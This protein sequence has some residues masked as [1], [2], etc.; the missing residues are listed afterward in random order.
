MM[1]IGCDFH[2]SW[3][4]VSWLDTETGE[5][6]EQKLVQASGD[7]ERFYRRVAPPALIGMEATGNCH[8]LVDL[9]SELGH[10]LWVGDAAQIRAS[11]VRQQKTDK[12]DAAHILKLLVEGRFP[13]IWMPS[14][15]VRDL[16]QLLLHRYKLVMIRARVKN[17]LQHLCLNQGVQR[18][19]KLWS[20]AGQQGLREL[21][22]TTVGGTASRRLAETDGYA[23][24]A[25][26]AAGGGGE[27][28][29]ARRQNGA[30]AS[31]PTRSGTD[32][33]SGLCADHGRCRPR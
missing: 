9:L 32:H 23:R 2:P 18:K 28:R 17:E 14:S 5:T 19:R 13:R 22:L 21:P 10:E 8:W 7:A 29:S 25:D 20:Q 24:S 16:R 12:R 33:S 27:S 4:Q 11:Y 3:Q 30:T 31:D 15:Q 6:G 1:I 26:R